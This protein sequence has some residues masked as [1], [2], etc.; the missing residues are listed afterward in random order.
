MFFE[1]IQA[2][3]QST[4]SGATG[5]DNADVFTPFHLKGDIPQYL[6]GS[7]SLAKIF[8]FQDRFSHVEDPNEVIARSGD[9]NVSRTWIRLSIT[10]SRLQNKLM[11]LQ[12]R[13]Q[14]DE[15]YP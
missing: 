1:K 2:P 5:S 14:Q 12:C 3:K 15:M 6:S 11:Q 10:N 7:K 8:D 13:F 4:L 9:A